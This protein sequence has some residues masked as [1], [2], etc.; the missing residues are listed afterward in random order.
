MALRG[1]LGSPK[2]MT[3][4]QIYSWIIEKYPYYKNAGNGW[5]N[6][7]RHNLSLN[8]TFMKVARPKEDPGKVLPSLRI[9][10]HEMLVH[11]GDGRR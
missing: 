7:I 3:L 2:K 1:V 5:K 11:L 9:A 10:H 4:A 8:R 6:S